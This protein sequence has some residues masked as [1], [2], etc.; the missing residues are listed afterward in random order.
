MTLAQPLQANSNKIEFE[1]G[2]YDGWLTYKN[3]SLKESVAMHVL[4]DFILL[5]I[6]ALASQS[7]TPPPSNFAAS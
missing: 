1:C 4:Y 5:G 3:H 7:Y 6:G 2:V